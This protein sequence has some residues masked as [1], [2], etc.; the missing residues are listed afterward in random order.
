MILKIYLF[1]VIFLKTFILLHFFQEF[2]IFYVYPKCLFMPHPNCDWYFHCSLKLTQICRFIFG[3]GGN[4]IS[5]EL[6]ALDRFSPFHLF[7]FYSLFDI[8]INW[9]IRGYRLWT[10]FHQIQTK[11]GLVFFKCLCSSKSINITFKTFF[12]LFV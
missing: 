11:H 2:F 10:K 3:G 5:N 6:G 12:C 4:R 9:K 1:S 7:L 8:I